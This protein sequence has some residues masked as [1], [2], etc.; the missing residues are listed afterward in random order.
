MDTLLEAVVAD[1]LGHL[2]ILDEALSL[3]GVETGGINFEFE[4]ESVDDLDLGR[5]ESVE[6]NHAFNFDELDII[7]I[8][9]FVPFIF[10]YSDDAGICLSCSNNDKRLGVLAIGICDAE[11]IT[12]V[13]EGETLGTIGL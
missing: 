11:V 2:D 9:E 3:I 10:M 6:F 13:Q 1:L 8:L 4:A 12:I 7:A 5:W